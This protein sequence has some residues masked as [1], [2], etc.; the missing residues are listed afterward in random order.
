MEMADFDEMIENETRT[1]VSYLTVNAEETE[2][3][4]TPRLKYVHKYTQTQAQVSA[5]GLD[6]SGVADLS[7]M[8]NLGK[9]I[10]DKHRQ[11]YDL[12]IGDVI[13]CV[14]E[15]VKEN[16]TSDAGGWV[17]L[18]F[19]N[20][21]LQMALLE[22]KL[23]GMVPP[24]G[25]DICKSNART[26]RIVAAYGEHDGDNEP[27]A[28][29]GV[30]LSHCVKITRHNDEMKNEKWN[31]FF[32]YYKGR[33]H[34]CR[35]HPSYVRKH[36]R[37]AADTIVGIMLD[38]GNGHKPRKIFKQI[39][40]FS[41]DKSHTDDSDESDIGTNFT[42]RQLTSNPSSVIG[43]E[44][45]NGL[46]TAMNATANQFRLVA[47]GSG[48]NKAH[49][50]TDYAYTAYYLRDTWDAMESGYLGRIKELLDAK[51]ALFKE[52][53]ARDDAVA[54]AT[55]RAHRAGNP[56]LAE[57]VD[58]YDADGLMFRLQCRLW[59]HVDAEWERTTRYIGDALEQP[60]TTVECTGTLTGI[61]EQL[62]D[63]ELTRAVTTVNVLNRYYDGDA[64]E[65]AAGMAD[66]GRGDPRAS[67]VATFQTFCSDV[68]SGFES[69]VRA[70]RKVQD[71]GEEPA[72]TGALTEI[73]RLANQ[74]TRIGASWF[75][76]K[77]ALNDLSA[78]D[79]RLETARAVHRSKTND[80]NNVCKLLERARRTSTGR[81]LVEQISGRFAVN[82]WI[83]FEA[84]CNRTFRDTGDNFSADRLK[85]MVD[86]LLADYPAYRTPADALVDAFNGTRETAYSDVYPKRWPRNDRFRER[87]A[88]KLL[89]DNATTAVDWRDLVVQC[90]EL[91]CPSTDQL[92]S[93]REQFAARDTDGDETV[94]DDVFD[95]IR[96]WFEDGS[97]RTVAMKRLL[98]DV[99]RGP[100]N[101]RVHYGALLLAFCRDERPWMGLAKAFAL[102]FGR[103]PSDPKHTLTDRPPG[104]DLWPQWRYESDGGH[105]VFD[106]TAMAWLLNTSLG[107]YLDR[108]RGKP[109]GNH[110]DVARIVQSVFARVGTARTE[111]AIIDLFRNSVMDEALYGAV[112]KFH[113]RKLSDVAMSVVIEHDVCVEL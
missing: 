56:R 95:A 110:V 4:G 69:R 32:D 14:G 8:A 1:S 38:D 83:V 74:A 111:P 48:P 98:G 42:S 52:L 28:G 113:A 79:G 88:R 18:E 75:A 68:A 46:A 50:S 6:G 36:A 13:N 11:N 65:L 47:S 10:D 89:G 57:L 80:V 66:D 39:N 53:K 41:D 23:T 105:F 49:N 27:A 92:L 34:V 59:D 61:Y 31:E 94:T 33:M 63:T 96:L 7:P 40:V 17:L 72:W 87:F 90:A 44:D 84:V 71:D 25:R 24:Y 58:E 26:S 103:D 81:A 76:D 64:D 54:S 29:T 108:G 5:Y 16:A 70:N 62:L 107:P 35:I 9:L 3:S 37:K 112:Y 67:R 73:N 20:Q 21:P 51:D 93:C 102:L 100:D 82:G 60:R 15:F 91:P 30:S 55:G 101:R 97:S 19:P 85:T 2:S 78:A 22:Y 106:A 12:Q 86:R 104:D 99:Y 109:H 45:K 43:T 77:A